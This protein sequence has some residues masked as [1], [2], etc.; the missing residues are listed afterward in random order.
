MGSAITKEVESL[1]I[2]LR[3]SFNPAIM[4]PGWLL[5]NGLLGEA[6]ANQAQPEIIIP[7]I[8]IFTA[9]WLRC[10]V[11]HDQMLFSTVEP[12]EFERARDVAVGVLNIL[13]H[14]P[15]AF[16]GLNHE[17]HI[18]A[19]SMDV[20]HRL[21]DALAPKDLW[22]P[23]LRLPGMRSVTI[24]GV[25]PDEFA[26]HIQVSVQPSARV[27]PGIYVSYNDHYV[28]RTVEEQ[29]KTRAD[30]VDPA[31]ADSKTVPPSAELIPLAIKIL[32]EKWADSRERSEAI[33]LKVMSAGEK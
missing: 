21:G 31:I 18:V 19:S 13:E 8:S 14:T 23:E 29:P 3:G 30:F 10:Q 9:A 7:D 24:E 4:S 26:G 2:V 25:R 32:S 1:S 16:L 11:T 6:E 17:A 22:E 28:L 5:A 12:Q 15:V 33:F 27:Q 20:W